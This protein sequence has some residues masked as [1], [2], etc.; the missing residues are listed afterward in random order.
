[1]CLLWAK[2]VGL[3]CEINMICF[4]FIGVFA[5]RFFVKKSDKRTYCFDFR[6]ILKLELK[7]KQT[8]VVMDRGSAACA[9]R[10]TRER[11]RERERERGGAISVRKSD[12]DN[13]KY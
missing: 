9:V 4:D 6:T 5:V 1:V 13:G 12:D 3:L 11:E 8:N 10:E 7:H 2:A